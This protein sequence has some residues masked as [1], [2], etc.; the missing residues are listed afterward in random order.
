VNKPPVA[1]KFFFNKLLKFFF[2]FTRENQFVLCSSFLHRTVIALI[3]FVPFAVLMLGEKFRLD[4]LW[5]A[6]CMLGAV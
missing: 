3:V 2:H 1:P 6:L 4:F 5:A